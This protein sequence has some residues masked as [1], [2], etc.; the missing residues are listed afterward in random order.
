LHASLGN[1]PTAQEVKA[2]AERASRTLGRRWS[3]PNL[4]AKKQLANERFAKMTG[5]ESREVVQMVFAGTAP[6]GERFGVRVELPPGQERKRRERWHFHIR[7]RLV[8]Q[9]GTSPAA[10]FVPADPGDGGFLGGPCQED[11]L[12]GVEA[13]RGTKAACH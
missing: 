3:D 9:W 6:A 2:V 11:L 13:E 7:G 4:V 8:D 12:A 10:P 1:V 5:E